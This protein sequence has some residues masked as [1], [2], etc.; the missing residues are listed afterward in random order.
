MRKETLVWTSRN[1]RWEIY[2]VETSDGYEYVRVDDTKRGLCQY[3]ML[4]DHSNIPVYDFPE[5]IPQYVKSMTS[6]ILITKR[7]ERSQ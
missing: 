3:P 2:H 5:Q 1:E 6:R 4:P 7:E